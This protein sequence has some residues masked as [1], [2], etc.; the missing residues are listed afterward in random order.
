MDCEM[1]IAMAVAVRS[2]IRSLPSSIR[3]AVEHSFSSRALQAACS[4]RT[5]RAHLLR[6][7]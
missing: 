3:H 7:F 2:S 5:D 1:L 4:Q 6:K